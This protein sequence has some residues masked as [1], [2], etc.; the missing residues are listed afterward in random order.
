LRQGRYAEALGFYAEAQGIFESLGEPTSVANIWHQIGMVHSTAGQFEKAER[1]YR[2]SLVINVQMKDLEG[3]AGSLY[4]LGSL[5]ENI[6]HIEEAVAFYKQVVDIC[7]KLRNPYREGM[8]RAALAFSLINLQRY[9]DARRE[10][11]RAI[12]CKKLYGHAVGI[13]DTWDILRNL[14]QAIGDSQAAHQ[15]RQ[16]AI[17]SYLAYRRASGQS[18]TL[19]AQL[20][21]IAAQV[22]PQGDTTK[23]EQALAQLSEAETTPPSGKLLIHNLQ[24]ILKGERDPALADDPNLEYDDAVELI[25]LL[26]ALNAQ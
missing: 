25:L 2:Q 26:E 8:A 9:D 12:E 1:A 15:A 24:A 17:E 16:Q 13:W 18:R 11:L 14:E 23:L 3:E 4:E 7:V 10:L 21:A 6:G 19:G 22:I 20:C 5:Y